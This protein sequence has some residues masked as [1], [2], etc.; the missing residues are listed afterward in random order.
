MGGTT[1]SASLIQNGALTRVSEYEFRAGIS[2]PSRFIKAGGYMMSVPTVDVAE[3]GSGA[4]SIAYVD[5]GGL[6]RV[7]PVSAG[8]DPGPACYGIGGERPTVTDANLFLGYLPPHLAG[9][10]RLLS[11]DRAEAAIARDLAAP[12]GL[13]VAQAAFGVR[14][15][16]TSN[17]AR[18]IRAVTVERGVDPRDFTLVAIGGS[19]PVHAADI[20]RLLAMPRVLVPAAPGVFTAMGML[21][22][23]VERYL[24]RPFPGRLAAIDLAQAAQIAGDLAAEAR[25]A[26]R[27][28]GVSDDRIA[29][30]PEID[31][32][33]R[34]QEISLA[35]PL[36]SDATA[37]SLRQ[38]FLAVYGAIYSYTSDDVVET[39]SIRLV[40]RGLRD[41]KLDF[42]SV[43]AA[44]GG[45][46]TPV[47][48]R[49]V[50]FG[51]EHGWV[52]TPIYARRGLPSLV[53][54]PAIV[55]GD[56]STVVIPPDA[57]ATADMRQNLTITFR[58][59]AP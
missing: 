1:A 42:R 26:L 54:G 57:I 51:G 8:A 58:E 27:A 38:A 44:K 7:G 33:F 18:A 11:R 24:I 3:V 35:V 47:S 6:M 56:D 12:F 4:G 31:L 29:T 13:D 59:V 25:E 37:E 43:A 52:E 53:E 39:V 2:T 19:G 45:A 49:P 32:R 15:V 41:G 17:M 50:Y 28:E 9:G 5:D 14:E 46:S 55:E 21:A 10:S 48:R 40:G 34:G 22:G 16:V 20:A 36:S 30:E 23:D